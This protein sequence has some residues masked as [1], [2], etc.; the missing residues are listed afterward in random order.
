MQSMVLK[1]TGM[2]CKHCVMAVTRALNDVPG[3]T[4]VEVSLENGRAIV[5]GTANPDLLIRA[6][7]QEGYHALPLR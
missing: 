2:T 6:I 4:G 1:I 5:S 3:V 7:E